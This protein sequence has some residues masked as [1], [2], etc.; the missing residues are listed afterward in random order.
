MRAQ[1]YAE[2]GIGTVRRTTMMADG[3]LGAMG[4]SLY[5]TKRPFVRE[6]R[7]TTRQSPS[8]WPI[9]PGRAEHVRPRR[10]WG[11]GWLLP[12]PPA[13]RNSAMKSC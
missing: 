13:L 3:I 4:L 5:S 8:A 7:T 6:P 9:G 10:G 2:L 11:E 12:H 1:A